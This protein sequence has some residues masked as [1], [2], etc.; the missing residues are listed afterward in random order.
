MG[1][2]DEGASTDG[3][4]DAPDTEEDDEALHSFSS[5]VDSVEKR[6]ER[7]ADQTN[8]DDD[9]AGGGS[10]GH[11]SGRSFEQFREE[12]A[13]EGERDEWRMLEGPRKTQTSF[14]EDPKSEAILEVIGDVPNVLLLGPLLGPADYDACSRLIGTV[15][16]EPDRLLLL[17]LSQSA[18][19]R[20]NVIRG[21]LGNLPPETVVIEVGGSGRSGVRSSVATEDDGEI[22]VETVSDPTDLR[23][24]GI[25]ISQY[26]ADWEDP[27]VDAVLCVHS[28][29]AL[30]QFNDDPRFLFRFLHVLQQKVRQ[31]GA[32]AHYHLDADAH[33]PGVVDRFRPLFDEALVFHEDGSLAVVR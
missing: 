24:I 28:I 8:E 1:D 20:L 19:E 4:P 17:S 32:T 6:R 7:L 27:S 29:T 3:D 23:R 33:E 13:A 25:M 14:D 18:E 5:L 2:E 10:R 16:S 31:Y 26:L 22:T 30:L 9:A 11:R 15:A 12:D 21:Y